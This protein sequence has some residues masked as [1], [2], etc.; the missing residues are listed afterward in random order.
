M[1][2]IFNRLKNISSS[3]ASK[4]QE[5]FD[6]NKA[7]TFLQFLKDKNEIGGF[8]SK[9]DYPFILDRHLI[10]S[11]IHILKINDHLK[12]NSSTKVADVGSG[13][14]LP[15]F[16]FHCLVNNPELTLIDSQRRKLKHLED[17]S[18]A[19]KYSKLIF[20][21]E[22]MESVK[23]NFDIVTM[24]SSIP[25]PWSIEMV[26]GLIKKEGYFIPFL[27][28][29]E[30]ELERENSFLSKFGFIIEHKEEISEL[31]FLGKRQV[32]YLKKTSFPKDSLPRDWNIIQKEI[33]RENG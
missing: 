4:A 28:K 20:T 10:E 27:G 8:F 29:K 33:R 19:N 11:L 3:I 13:P 14:G 25:Y 32:K 7:E 23:K 18:K 31:E 2:I 6:L 5:Y 22:R 16:L 30:I 1:E 21:Y 17:F 9:S 24:R 26:S 15:G 12:L